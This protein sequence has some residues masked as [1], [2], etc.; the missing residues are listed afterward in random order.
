[1]ERHA[2]RI[3]NFAHR[4]L[5]SYADAEEVAQETF[6]R[7]YRTPPPDRAGGKLSTWLYRVAA[8]LCI[9]RLRSRSRRPPMVSLD[10]PFPGPVRRGGRAADPPPLREMVGP[11]PTAAEEAVRAERQA[12]VREAVQALPPKLRAPLVLAVFDDLPQAEIA[13]VL[14]ITRKAVERRIHQA[15]AL[16]KRRLCL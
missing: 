6:L 5:A 13:S 10:D 16:L 7:L 1:M 11:A 3:V 12:A 4:L 9:D 15:R 14:G 8:N 2:G